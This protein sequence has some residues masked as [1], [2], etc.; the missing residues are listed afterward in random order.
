MPSFPWL[1]FLPDCPTRGTKARDRMSFYP[2]LP[3]R[4]HLIALFKRFPR[5][6][7]AILA[8]ND[9]FLR[10]TDSAL[11]VGERELIAAHVS[12]VNGCHYCFVA[13]R[14]YAEA[15]GMAPEVFGDMAVDLGHDSLR[16]WMTAALAFAG[17]LAMDP[18]RVTRQDHEALMAAGFDEDTI[19]EIVSITAIYAMMNRILEGSGMKENVALAGVTAEKTRAGRYSD[20]MAY[21]K[22]D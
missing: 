12:A 11:E 10:D 13:H 17:K 9:A 20:A 21:I 1:S 4:H 6:A 14:R 15:F 2:S 22:G 5:G 16:P 7:E 8:L 19:H 18:G 3:D